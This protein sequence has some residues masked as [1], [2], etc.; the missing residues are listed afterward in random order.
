MGFFLYFFWFNP[1]QTYV[2]YALLQTRPVLL[3]IEQGLEGLPSVP[4]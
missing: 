3:L 2:Y 1:G 4:P